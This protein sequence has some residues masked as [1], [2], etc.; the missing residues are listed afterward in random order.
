MPIGDKIELA[1]IV[2]DNQGTIQQTEEKAEEVWQELLE[3]EK[4]K[5]S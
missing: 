3:R 5:R 1:D 4:S 2:I